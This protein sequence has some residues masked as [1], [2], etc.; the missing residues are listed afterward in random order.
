LANP[1]PRLGRLRYLQDLEGIVCARG[2]FY[3]NQVAAQLKRQKPVRID[4]RGFDVLLTSCP[5]HTAAD[6]LHI[7][8][9]DDPRS[10]PP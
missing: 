9:A 5:L 3:A 1:Y 6:R 10:H 8:W 4:L 2:V 7:R